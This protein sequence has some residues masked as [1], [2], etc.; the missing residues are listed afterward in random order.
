M[1]DVDSSILAQVRDWF[2]DALPERLGV[3][4]SGGGDSVAL[5]HILTRCFG[6]NGP[7]IHAV[8]VDHGL[9]AESADEA[10]M[11]ARM[12]GALSVPHDTLCW[13][14]WDGAGNL[15]DQAR[16]A[17]YRL[18]SRWARSSGIEMLALAH[19]ADDQAETVLMRLG[20]AAG[21][22]GL[23]GIPERRIEGGVTFV[24]PLLG[25][26]R[27]ALRAYLVRNAIE[28]VEDPSNRDDRFDRIRARRALE[29]LQ[30]LGITVTA[31]ADV[32]RHMA[33]A[34]AALDWYSFLAAR[35]VARLDAGDVLLDRRGFSDSARRGRAPSAGPGRALGRRGASIRPGARRWPPRSTRFG[36][37]AG[38]RW[39]AA[40]WAVTRSARGCAGNMRRSATRAVPRGDLGRTLAAE[41]SGPAR[42]RDPCAGPRRAGRM[43][44]LARDGAPGRVSDRHALRLAGR[45]A[46]RRAGRRLVR[47]MAGGD[48]A[49]RRG[50]LCLVFLSH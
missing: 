12:A 13:E 41:R 3:A 10:A 34:R 19:T 2:G 30:P 18:L 48:H 9:R 25:V 44:V 26:T 43:S 6:E 32:A 50:V 47:A 46:D 20:R 29:A 16:R 39:P 7:E 28:W 40:W 22:D 45:R 15:Q 42:V 1:T 38:L 35:D 36:T 27:Q 17:R 4:V 24:R 14:G 5:L 49:G 11:V 21:V 31:L 37:G 8:T 33:Q 23:S